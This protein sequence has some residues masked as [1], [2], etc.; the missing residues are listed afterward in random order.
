MKE[1]NGRSLTKHRARILSTLRPRKPSSR[2]QLIVETGLSAATVSRITRELVRKK[3]LREVD[4]RR[5]AVGRPRRVLEINGSYGAVLG[6]SVLPPAAR[7]VVVNLEGRVLHEAVC[8]LGWERGPAAIL[9]ALKRLV[10]SSFRNPPRGTPPLSAVGLAVPGQWDRDAGSW[11]SFPRVTDWKTVP[12]RRHLEQWTGARTCLI[13]YASA[14]A[15]AEQAHRAPDELR[16]LLCIEVT[17]NI[18]MGVIVNDRVLEGASGNAGEL[19]HITVDPSG[20]VCY[21]G[22]TGCLETLATCRTAVEAARQGE[23]AMHVV[24]K[25]S[26]LTYGR[27]VALAQGG[28][29][30]TM[31]LL[32][33]VA[34]TLGVGI[35]AAANLFNPELVVLN[36]PF[37]DAGELV[38]GPL[39]ISIQNRAIHNTAKHVR[40]ERSTLG[41]AAPALGAGMVAI[42]D[43]LQRV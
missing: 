19:G 10:L 21:C 4:G 5:A 40:I 32:G 25:G 43:A 18:A 2:A 6:V 1:T 15:V 13:G 37:F 7:A 12:I 41:P 24:G 36:G 23:A 20:P 28:D 14:L 3:V 27:V 35:A 8:P 29:A 26:A 38:L 9:G 42:R 31:R 34:T 11:I 16:E 30:F 22:N 17:D 39:R 33:R